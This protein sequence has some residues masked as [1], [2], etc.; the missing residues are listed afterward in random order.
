MTM[1]KKSFLEKIVGSEKEKQEE[2]DVN[3]I[4]VNNDYEKEISDI[5]KNSAEIEN[6]GNENSDDRKEEENV[7]VET[8]ENRVDNQNWNEKESAEDGQLTVDVYKSKEYIIIKSIIG[9]VRPEDLDISVTSDMVTIKG[10][11]NNLDEVNMDDYYYQECFWGNFSRSI[12]LPNDIKTEGVEAIIKNG[13]LTLKLPKIEKNSL[14]KIK[15]IE[16]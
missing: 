15:V 2:N 6:S 5:M 7:I 4:E 9:G 16:E 14:T 12:I 3:R 8:V 13:I 11:R 10:K 1:K